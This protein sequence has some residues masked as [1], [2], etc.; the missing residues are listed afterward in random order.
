MQFDYTD[1]TEFFYKGT[2]YLLK[3]KYSKCDYL[4][5]HTQIFN[6]TLKK[7]PVL[8]QNSR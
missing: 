3:F 5:L 6:K 7:F 4:H 8:L 2:N 1:Y